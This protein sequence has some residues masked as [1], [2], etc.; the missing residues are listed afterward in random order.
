[1]NDGPGKK[2]VMFA[3]GANLGAAL[4]ALTQAGA[5]LRAVLVDPVVSAVYRT[6]PEGGADQPTYLNAVVRGR[7]SLSPRDALAVAVRLEG[8]AGRVRTVPGAARV[9][10]VDVLFVGQEVVDEPGL[11]VPH[12]RWATRDFVVVPLLD[13]A[14]EWRDPRTGKTVREVAESAGWTSARFPRVVG[15]GALLSGGVA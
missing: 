7:A 10:D 9:L 5:G 8:E 11:H 1:V 2:T 15:P 6:P 4:Q 12:R 14:P 3:L 13:V